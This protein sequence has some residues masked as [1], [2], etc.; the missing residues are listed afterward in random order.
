MVS[1]GLALGALLVLVAIWGLLVAMGAFQPAS[2][3]DDATEPP[4]PAPEPAEGE[5]G[6]WARFW[7][8]PLDLV[9]VFLGG[10]LFLPQLGAGGLW[11]P[12]ETHY[13]EVARRML[14]RDDWISMWW[15]NEWFYS[16]PV[17]IMWIDAIGMG[18]VGGNP[19][20]DGELFGAAWGMR[21]P[22]TLLA[23]GCMWA[24]YRLCSVRFGNRA[25]FFAA[26]VLGTMPTFGFL[27]HQT[28][29]DMPYVAPMSIALCLLA[30]ALEMDDD[31]LLRGRLVQLGRWGSIELNGHQVLLGGLITM[32]L[33]FNLYLLSLP[34]TFEAGSL[35]QD[36]VRA[37]TQAVPVPLAVIGCAALAGLGVLLWSLRRERR[38]RRLYLLGG[39][40]FV[41]LAV[42]GK[43]LPG[44]VLPGMVLFFYLLVTGRWG[45]LRRLEIGR[46]LGMLAVIILPWYL[47]VIFR[48]GGAFIDRIIFHD[49]VNR[50]VVGVH[51]DT[52]TIEYY[53]QQLGYGAFPWLA[54]VPLAL[55]GRAWFRHDLLDE[56]AGRT[57]AFV[58]L[59]LFSFFVFFSAVITKFH[60]Y[61]FPVI[62]PLAI[63]VGLSLHDLLS[64]R[65]KSPT[66]LLWGGLGLAGLVG[67]DLARPPAM[68]K[69]GYERFVDLFIYNYS[70]QWPEGEQYDF[71][72]VLTS[73][74]VLVLVCAAVLLVPRLRRRLGGAPLVAAFVFGIWTLDVYMP[75]AGNHWSQR[76]LMEAYYEER[77]SDE[78]RLVAYQM[79]WKGE[80][81]YT[82]NRVVVF[83]SL[84]TA[85]FERWVR[86]HAGERHF[87][88]TERSRFQ[89]MRAALN[90]AR[91]G[92]GT[93]MEEIGSPPGPDRGELCNKFRMGV[94]TL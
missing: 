23:I 81:F 63:L 82:G 49:V 46:G 38:V 57:R 58:V 43:V 45:E 7:R 33:P 20:P 89:G 74:V 62:I 11:D 47:A 5:L 28:M 42:L 70:R 61:I 24:V 14:E 66:P 77:D 19:Y 92:A 73:L 68:G 27:A 25:G 13:G 32:V 79:N 3:A 52:G 16:K 85:A 60:H 94:T 31:R 93:R 91:P 64:R 26:L 39:Y 40:F 22:V 86:E 88:I 69:A 37:A 4:A 1:F 54:L 53:L 76:N 6:W 83:V 35:G 84:D 72:E 17:L 90:R 65:I 18:L 30:I 29:T 10:L 71:T 21:L 75:A 44:I 8:R 59:W 34:Q 36:N 9:V 2:G 55:W 87:F 78:E 48:H 50:A 41:G 51:G 67:W 12:W 56:P 15:Q 80:N